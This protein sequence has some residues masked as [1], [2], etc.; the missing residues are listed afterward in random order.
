MTQLSDQSL[1]EG[2]QIGLYEIKNVLHIGQDA[3]TYRAWSY[4]FNASVVLKEYFPQQIVVRSDDDLTVT[5]AKEGEQANFLNGLAGFLESTEELV[6]IEHPNVV[7]T[8]NVLE[9]NGTAYMILDYYDNESLAQRLK[10][11]LAFTE[12]DV[13]KLFSPL[14]EA[15]QAIHNQ[16]LCHG[17]VR[18]DNILLKDN[19]QP[20]LVGF[21]VLSVTEL[22]NSDLQPTPESDLY[23]LAEVMY[24]CIRLTKPV[25]L[26]DRLAAVRTG[27]QDPFEPLEKITGLVSNLGVLVTID[28]MLSLDERQRPQTATAAGV[29]LKNSFSG[30][31]TEIEDLTSEGN[32]DF[33]TT[34]KASKL[35]PALWMSL[36]GGVVLLA[37]LSFWI[38]PE[39]DGKQISTNVD[40]SI[41]P[42]QP[43]T[44][45]QELVNQSVEQQQEVLP[46]E[47]DQ[48][49]IVRT[50]ELQLLEQEEVELAESEVES[51]DSGITSVT[52]VVESPEV[53]IEVETNVD[54]AAGVKMSEIT[55][56]SDNIV[57]TTAGSMDTNL[58][59]NV[60]QKTTVVSSPSKTEAAISNWAKVKDLPIPTR[61]NWH[62]AEAEKN[63]AEAQLTTPVENNAFQHYR[64][65]LV[66]DPDNAEAKTGMNKIV[67]YYAVLITRAL[68]EGR[69]NRADI[70]LRRAEAV[71]QDAPAIMHLRKQA[72]EA[73][74]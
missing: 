16:G 35:E 33:V 11:E 38:L 21:S 52:E 9:F 56:T 7:Q 70:Y 43:I 51:S 44:T 50:E 40:N 65:V 54:E 42:I 24:Q 27:E 67:E 46:A 32:H 36:L 10:S 55:E 66:L 15:L 69:L 3:I 59:D 8:Q 1:S 64:I 14:L 71:A 28:N 30:Q 17:D 41:K 62:L 72:N 20:M 2:A 45:T 5:V 26:S 74:Q 18:P 22:Y 73:G 29:A 39:D 23:Q 12:Y 53:I 13:I 19:Q 37:L 25:V 48:E 61:I 63:L 34:P 47:L 4:H 58:K 60:S 68:N 31:D 6:Q 57:P 49:V